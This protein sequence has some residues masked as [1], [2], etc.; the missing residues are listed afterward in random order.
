MAVLGKM[1]AKV[2]FERLQGGRDAAGAPIQTWV[3]LTTVSAR[4]RYMRGGESVI[5]QRITG[6]QPV[7]VTV[8]G[9]AATR[10]IKL[11][12]RGL[13]E[14]TGKVLHIESLAPDETGAFIEI[15]CKAT[16]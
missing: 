15:L 9:S 4:V 10:Q 7:V 6:I 14:R 11:E 12:D 16:T 2:R 13:D 8:R 3:A 5:A 1:R